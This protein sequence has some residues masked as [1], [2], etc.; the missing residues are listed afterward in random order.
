MKR[1]TV[2]TRISIGLVCS[3]LG[4][5]LAAN[6]VGLLPD[7]ERMIIGHRAQVAESL[8]FSASALIQQDN[9]DGLSAVM[10][11]LVDRHD[12]LQSVGI[13]NH[14][15]GLLVDSGRHGELWPADQP[16]TSDAEHMQ[17]P[18]TR[19]DDAQWG[20]IELCFAPLHTSGWWA[21][22]RS[23]LVVLLAFCAIGGFFAFRTFLRFVLKNLD[24]SRAVPRRV[25]E[26][27]DI[28]AEG[29]MIVGVD[30]RILLANKALASVTGQDAESL[31]GRKASE[32][33]FRCRVPGGSQP[34]TEAFAQEKSLSNVTMDYFAADGARIFNVNC[35]PLLGNG[36]KNRGVMVTF[37]DV[38]TLEQH[39]IE[40]RAAKD[41]ADAANKAKSDFLANMSHEIRNPMN[42]I[43]GFTDILRR[44]LEENETTRTEYLNTIHAS[45]THLM[46]LINDILDLSKIEA[47][48]MEMELCDC[49]PFQVVAEV[50]NVM[51]M[52]A[53]QQNLVLESSVRG[54]IP[55]MILTDQTR[56]RQILMN[57]VGN[58]IKF[59][60][61]GSVRIVTELIDDP[62]R[63]MLKF[64]VSDTGIGM[65]AEQCGKIFEEFTQ[66]DSSVNRR[67]GG[68]G[69]G[70]A[71]SKRL[72]EALGGTI[73]VSSRSGQGSTFTFTVTTGNI[74]MVP[75]I[76]HDTAV[77][78]LR[79]TYQRHK[80]GLSV[81]FKRAR[82]LI[83]DDTAANRQ[84]V[85]LVL[86]RAGLHVEEAKNGLEAV[87]RATAEKF[88]LLLM[89]MQMPVMDGFTATRKLREKG[90]NAP[91]IALTANVMASD[92]E[93][94]EQAGCSGFLTKPID[95]DNLL[96]A[97]A[98]RLPTA[99][100]RQEA[101]AG[102]ETTNFNPY[103][104]QPAPGEKRSPAAPKGAAPAIARSAGVRPPVRSAEQKSP[105]PQ[106]AVPKS[107]PA[108]PPTRRA[109]ETQVA[110]PKQQPESTRRPASKPKTSR[111][112]I[113]STLPMEIPEFRE[114][115]EQFVGGLSTTLGTMQSAWDR[116]DFA[117]LRDHAHRLKGTGGTVGFH[118]F[119]APAAALQDRAEQR[120]EADIDELLAELH[121]LSH[122]IQLPGCGDLCGVAD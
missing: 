29:L 51:Q 75:R 122:A 32:L 18:L 6:Y 115:V 100:V 108:V 121:E 71:I 101:T 10:K 103:V 54:K 73:E 109:V 88:D 105:A 94:C 42:A 99:D 14:S 25:R 81:T 36:G 117:T 113:T 91:I 30:D 114:I 3:M 2:G 50:V 35:S 95:I 98:E 38:T 120:A 58:A 102:T 86:R 118:Q 52:K 70:L 5:L 31:I 40:L 68:T 24:P 65:T 83:T 26:A 37:D 110:A 107:R 87:K 48:K 49:S 79:N 17:V 61:Q 28:L 56:L 63:P 78:D 22:L 89:D 15:D 80:S 60:Q 11:G 96:Q 53:Q 9:I 106:P 39:K 16:I 76:D 41:E 97:L 93:R 46:D 64:E 45:G 69:L 33:G 84:L 77:T 55:R 44:G 13:R 66:A 1:L 74:S 90:M 85:G 119:T 8:A 23:Q 116:R 21:P 27:L 34:W 104:D 82:V 7:R 47:G 72:T 12:D 4:I 57:L 111:A 43:V 67:F 19:G 62:R 92:R 59:T 112:P 20:Q